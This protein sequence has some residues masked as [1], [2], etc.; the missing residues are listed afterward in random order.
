MQV[1]RLKLG[2]RDACKVQ[3]W[4]VIL[5][6]VPW[7]SF[8]HPTPSFSFCLVWPGSAF[9]PAGH[10]VPRQF[11][12]E[13]EERAAGDREWAFEAFETSWTTHS[14]AWIARQHPTFNGAGCSSLLPTVLVL[15]NTCSVLPGGIWT[16][17][18][19]ET[20]VQQLAIW[21]IPSFG[22]SNNRAPN[23]GGPCLFFPLPCVDL[24]A[25]QHISFAVR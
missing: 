2:T 9:R 10:Q 25:P 3:P 15:T 19:E 14:T 13:R 22:K 23:P 5:A 4:K 21:D 11:L 8:H 17:T 24:L 7:F 18:R 6:L 16:G 1:V 20:T 12:L